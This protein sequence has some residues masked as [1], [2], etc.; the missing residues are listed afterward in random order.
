MQ[1]NFLDP[2]EY[3][4]STRD[5]VVDENNDLMGLNTGA[6]VYTGIINDVH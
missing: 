3:C 2:R 6:I 1:T 4:I 5:F